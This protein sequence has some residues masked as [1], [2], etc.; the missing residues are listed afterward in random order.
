MDASR[1]SQLLDCLDL[2]R[3]E[4][5]SIATIAAAQDDGCISAGSRKS[6][7]AGEHLYQ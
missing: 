5:A 3:R 2:R 1:K 7:V 6:R 4:S